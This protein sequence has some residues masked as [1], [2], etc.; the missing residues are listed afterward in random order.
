MYWIQE[1]KIMNKIDWLIKIVIAAGI[2]GFLLVVISFNYEYFDSSD[3][4]WIDALISTWLAAG[5]VLI[6][7]LV[8]SAILHLLNEIK[9]KLYHQDK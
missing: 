5:L 4:E 7:S 6:G 2:I 3:P 9:K 1:G 8:V